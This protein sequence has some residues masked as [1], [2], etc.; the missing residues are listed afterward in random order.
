MPTRKTIKIDIYSNLSSSI[1]RKLMRWEELSCTSDLMT[2]TVEWIHDLTFQGVHAYLKGHIHNGWKQTHLHFQIGYSMLEKWEC[3]HNSMTL[4]I[5]Y[6]VH[7][8]PGH[9]SNIF[10][11]REHR[12]GAKTPFTCSPFNDMPIKRISP[13]LQ[14]CHCLPGVEDHS[15]SL[16]GRGKGWWIRSN[17]SPAR[18]S[19]ALASD[20]PINRKGRLTKVSL[21]SRW[22]WSSAL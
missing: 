16:L 7:N 17:L 22:R 11:S 3:R 4:Y 21:P 14:S 6:E 15:V 5:Y 10:E 12:S 1:E 19:R 13:G 20:T 18:R 8:S 9:H 2:M